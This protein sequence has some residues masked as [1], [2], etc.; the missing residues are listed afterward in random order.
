MSAYPKAC[1]HCGRVCK[2]QH[3]MWQH[4]KAKH[5]PKAA[6]AVRPPRRETEEPSLA[7]ELIEAIQGAYAGEPVP[8]HLFLMF[9]DQFPRAAKVAR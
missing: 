8:R 5:G 4:T 2:D 7:D 3:S 9:R 1:S 6:R